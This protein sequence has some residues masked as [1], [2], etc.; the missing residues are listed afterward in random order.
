M[1]VTHGVKTKISVVQQ[2]AKDKGGKLLSTK[3]VNALQKLRWQCACGHIF[4]TT[5]SHVKNRGQWCPKC[6]QK[7]GL[8]NTRKTFR[9]NPEIRKKISCGHQKIPV[10]QFSGFVSKNNRRKRKLKRHHK[11]WKTDIQYKLKISLRNRLKHAIKNNH[12]R[13]SAVKDL[14]CSIEELKKHLESQFQPGM[15]WDNWT[16]DGWH[17]DHIV[18]LTAFDLSNPKELKKACHYTNLQPLWA[19]DNLVKSNKFT[20]DTSG[21]TD[22]KGENNEQMDVKADE[23]LGSTSSRD[24]GA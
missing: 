24:E 5:F 23:G 17:I 19:K 20:P 9:E 16:T 18:P 14:G 3:Y 10:S 22:N 1:E 15:S 13:G 12:K 2:F 7:K 4:E 21:S 11:R 8:E 6:G